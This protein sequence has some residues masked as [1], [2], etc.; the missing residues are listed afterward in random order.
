LEVAE[1]VTACRSGQMELDT[2]AS[3]RRTRLT[4]E[5]DTCIAMAMSTTEIGSSIELTVKEFTR[6]TMALFIEAIGERTDNMELVLRSGWMASVTKALTR[7]ALST[8]W[9]LSLGQTAPTTRATSKIMISMA[10]VLILGL[11]AGV[12]LGTGLGIGCMA[13]E[14]FPGLMVDLLR[15]TIQMIKRRA[16]AFSAGPM[17]VFTVGSGK[18]ENNMAL[19]CTQPKMGKSST[20]CGTTA[21]PSTQKTGRMVDLNPK[22][23][24]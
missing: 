2:K 4:V 23:L 21:R 16:L 14:N 10:L 15:A 20:R 19:E 24:Q 7:M 22:P 3:G 9:A 17:A 18:L 11:T 1:T 12:M 6:R 13:R 8:V 5:D